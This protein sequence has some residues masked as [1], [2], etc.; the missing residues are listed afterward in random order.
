MEIYYKFLFYLKS[1]SPSHRENSPI[2]RQVA[3]DGQKLTKKSCEND[4]VD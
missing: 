3:N 1:F 4:T 2:I